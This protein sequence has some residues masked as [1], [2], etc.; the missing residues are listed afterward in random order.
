MR[1]SVGT[2]ANTHY[3]YIDWMESDGSHPIGAELCAAAQAAVME[4]CRLAEDQAW[5]LPALAEKLA[6]HGIEVE[7][8]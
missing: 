5:Q 1:I 7:R 8:V 4:A 3:G 2:D 6:K